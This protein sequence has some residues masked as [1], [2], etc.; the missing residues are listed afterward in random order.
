M[1]DDLDDIDEADVD[2]VVEVVAMAI[3]ATVSDRSR[4]G[5]PWEKL[6]HRLR[7]EYREEARAAIAAYKRAI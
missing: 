3:R 7:A 1:T 5:L 2:P 4:W 6:P